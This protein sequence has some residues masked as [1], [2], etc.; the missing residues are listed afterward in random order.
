M[1]RRIL[2][3]FLTVLLLLTGCAPIQVRAPLGPE[4]EVR[5][6]PDRIQP[7]H[8]L[9]IRARSVASGTGLRLAIWDQTLDLVPVAGAAGEMEGF[10]SVPLEAKP[11]AMNLTILPHPADGTS[12]SLPLE[13]VSRPA[14]ATVRLSIRNFER[15]PYTAESQTMAKVRAQAGCRPA[16]RLAGWIWPVRG[17]LSERFGVRRIYNDGLG[18]WRHGG[19]D[20]AA[21]GGTPVLA[22]AGG[23]VLFTAPFEAHGNTILIDHG[24]GVITTYLHLRAIRVRSGEDVGKGQV[25]GEVGS[26]GGSTADHLHFQI[27]IHGRTVEPDDFLGS[28]PE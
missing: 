15:L 17:R 2:S 13:I 24:F 10:L 28:M 12:R 25:I 7:G 6:I 16:P 9:R 8:L 5:V 1:M 27:N 22:P 3:R 4:V 14:D 19:Y 18:N 21:A 11:G 23:R 26:T 20:I